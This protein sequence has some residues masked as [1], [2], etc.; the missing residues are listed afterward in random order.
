MI[1]APF[2]G[3]GQTMVRVGYTPC[4]PGFVTRLMH[5]QAH[6]ARPRNWNRLAVAP[7]GVAGSPLPPHQSAAVVARDELQAM[8]PG[9]VP[10]IRSSSS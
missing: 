6:G 4:S 9:I 8:P 10:A 5:R 3:P 7:Q 2:V 1:P